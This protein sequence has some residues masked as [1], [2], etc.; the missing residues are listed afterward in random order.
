MAESTGPTGFGSSLSIHTRAKSQSSRLPGPSLLSTRIR[1]HPGRQV[2]V[3]ALRL[4]GRPLSPAHT[5]APMQPGHGWRG[6]LH[7]A[8]RW[9]GAATPAVARWGVTSSRRPRCCI[10]TARDDPSGHQPPLLSCSTRN[11]RGHGS[12]LQPVSPLDSRGERGRGLSPL[13]L[14]PLYYPKQTAGWKGKPGPIK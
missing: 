12:P 1:S 5:T 10:T 8:G 6:V 14:G 13:P 7:P 3:D 9:G 11:V 2:A 4:V